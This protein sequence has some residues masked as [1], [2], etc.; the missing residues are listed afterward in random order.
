M[1][2]KGVLG[3]YASEYAV[4]R[5]RFIATVTNIANADDAADFI[6]EVSKKYSDATHNCY[7]YIANPE[8]TEM[9]FS[10]ANE[11]QGTAGLPILEVLKKRNLACTAVVVT[12]YF[13]GIKLGTGGLSAAYAKATTE[14]LDKALIADFMYSDY[15]KL[16]TD[17]SMKGK[18][19][20]AIINNGG[21]IADTIYMSDVEIIYAVPVRLSEYMEEVLKGVTSGQIKS[22]KLYSKYYIYK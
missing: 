16:K 20:Q 19:E 8:M 9:K 15:Y 18:I 12:R 7:A 10:D 4:S 21:E 1:D 6:R 14:C 17:Y 22:E 11:P 5:S 3:Q 13:G 2:Y